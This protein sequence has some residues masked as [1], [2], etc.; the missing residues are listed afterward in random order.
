[1]RTINKH[2]WA[3]LITTLFWLFIISLLENCNGKNNTPSVDPELIY[4]YETDS[5]YYDR[6]FT[7]LDSVKG[8]KTK[9]HIVIKWKTPD[10][11]IDTIY[12]IPG[13]VII[14][15]DSLEKLVIYNDN[16]LSNFPDNPKLLKLRLTIDSLNITKLNPD[17]NIFEDRIPLS[18]Y[19]FDYEWQNRFYRIPV[20][21]RKPDDYS[22]L[23]NNYYINAE[24]NPMISVKPFIG[25]EYN[26]HWRR[27]KIDINTSIEIDK[28]PNF[29]LQGKLGYRL[30][31]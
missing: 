13:N 28:N 27:F 23:L 25:L 16:F 31:N 9:P 10:L 5:I 3:I 11:R 6:Y 21:Y 2:F 30:F 15:L 8:I 17:G 4:N 22:S 29:I 1:M 20:K 18:L 26:K 7:L 14:K 19:S 12:R 24:I